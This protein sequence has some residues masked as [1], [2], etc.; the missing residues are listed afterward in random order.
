MRCDLFIYILKDML[1]LVS[2]RSE[3]VVAEAAVGVTVVKIRGTAKKTKDI[4]TVYFLYFFRPLM[5]LT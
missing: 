1:G 3:E 5:L 2:D 4:Y